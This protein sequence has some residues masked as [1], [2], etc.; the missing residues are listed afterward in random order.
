[1]DARQDFRDRILPYRLEAVE[2]L[3]LALRYRLSWDGPVPMEV[4]FDGKLSI[5]GLS[6]AFTNPVIEAGI[7]H[8]RALLEFIGLRADPKNHGKLSPRRPSRRDDLMI[9]HFENAYG[10]IPLVSPAEAVGRT[11]TPLLRWSGRLLG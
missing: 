4:H 6:T 10:P 2:I 7:F 11:R 5:E 1:M 3:S 8:C 9:E